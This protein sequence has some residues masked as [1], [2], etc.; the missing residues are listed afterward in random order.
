AMP[1]SVA[2]WWSIRLRWFI[3]VVGYCLLLVVPI[4]NEQLTPAIGAVVSF[5]V[6][7]AA[8]VYALRVVLGNRKLLTRRLLN[9]ADNASLG[10]FAVVQRILARIWLPF[11][12]IYL[13]V[14]FI[15]SQLDAQGV[16]PFMLAATVKT[17]VAAA[18]ALGLSGLLS[19]ALSKRITVSDRTRSRL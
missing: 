19:R 5:V 8:F 9:R 11:A 10:F 13:T 12:I 4:A 7:A 2:G 14:L 18:I 1:D 6:M 3:G 16:L 15:G 17:L